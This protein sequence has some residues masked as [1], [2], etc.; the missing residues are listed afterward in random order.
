[1]VRTVVVGA[2]AFAAGAV[3]GGLFV[4]WY[5]MRHAGQLAGD[6]I[7]AEIFGEG[8]TGAKILGGVLTG[9]DEFRAQ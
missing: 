6:A 3:A 7:G 5:V 9:L 1:M 8:S 4:R 2:L